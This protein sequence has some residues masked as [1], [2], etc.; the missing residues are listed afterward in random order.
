MICVAKLCYDC[1]FQVKLNASPWELPL[2][3]G[4]VIDMRTLQTRN[5]DQSDLWTWESQAPY[6]PDDECSVAMEFFRDVADVD[7]HPERKGYD[8]C[9]RTAV[10]AMLCGDTGSKIMEVWH[11]RTGNNSK[12][13]AADILELCVPGCF[14]AISSSVLSQISNKGGGGPSPEKMQIV[15]KRVCVLGD[16]GKAICLDEE[17]IKTI[18]GGDLISARPCHGACINFRA[19]C[20]PLLITN[21]STTFDVQQKAMKDRFYYFPFTRVF[22]KCKANAAKIDEYKTTH[23]GEFFTAFIRGA[24]DYAENLELRTCPWLEDER[25][26]YIASINPI[27]SFIDEC[28]IKDVEEKEYSAILYERYKSWCALNGERYFSVKWFGMQ[29]TMLFGPTKS[30]R[31]RRSSTSTSTTLAKGYEGVKLVE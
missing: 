17:N 16:T 28:C 14:T 31:I 18:T 22:R 23:I 6:L 8:S 2:K 19:T 27:G 29:M 24:H 26:R 10:G 13:T 7:A 1:D 20:K 12:S 25:A 4:D 11:G 15:G 9:L 21:R 30:M 5:R 3:G